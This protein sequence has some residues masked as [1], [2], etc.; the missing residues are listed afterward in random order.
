[1]IDI[2]TI[3]WDLYFLSIAQTIAKGSKC[4]KRQVGSVIIDKDKRITSTG[5]NGKSRD[6][7]LDGEECVRLN[8][9]SGERLDIICCNCSEINNFLYSSY[10]ERQGGSMYL[11]H[12]PCLR[13]AIAILQSG[14]SQ[15]IYLTDHRRE[16]IDYII[17]ATKEN[18]RLALRE[19]DLDNHVVRW[20]NSGTEPPLWETH[21]YDD[22]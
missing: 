1:M 3:K 10:L 18:N 20:Y 12:I 9:P 7:C 17:R 15:L 21:E 13:C 14:I 4:V 22:S 5:M 11:T 8:I 16:G 2:K 6:I 19:Y